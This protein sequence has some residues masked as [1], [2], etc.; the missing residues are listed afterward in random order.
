MRRAGSISWRR[1]GGPHR[2]RRRTDII[3]V[4]DL[5]DMCFQGVWFMRRS[6]N[7]PWE[8]TGSVP[9]QID[10]IP[11]SSPS[12]NVTNVTVVE[13]QQRHGSLRHGAAYTG[14]GLRRMGH[15][16]AL[17][18]VRR[19]WRVLP[20]LPPLLPQLRL[21]R[22]VQPVGRLGT[23]AAFPRARP[24]RRRGRRSALQPEEGRLR[25]RAAAY[26]PSGARGVAGAYNPRTGTSAAT[27]QGS[28]VYGRLRDRSDC[29]QPGHRA[30]ETRGRDAPA[31]H[32]ERGG[33][34]AS[35]SGAAAKTLRARTHRRGVWLVSCSDALGRLPGGAS[36]GPA[37]LLPHILPVC[38]VVA[39]WPPGAA[40]RKPCTKSSDAGH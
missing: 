36:R 18:A 29:S 6:P 12:F 14:L 26:G 20:G 39:P 17:P 16:V 33:H 4:G 23:A 32:A 15:R 37:L 10:D 2:D 40:L 13:N 3:K 27:R 21:P 11:V 25:T 19:V 28:G 35:V 38:S 8:V 7:G 1:F 34:R 24:V 9:G 5:Y 31:V 30:S 22:L